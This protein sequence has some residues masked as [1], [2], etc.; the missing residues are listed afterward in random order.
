MIAG[1]WD[2]SPS[3]FDV[4]AAGRTAARAPAVRCE[5]GERGNEGE[6]A[7]LGPCIACISNDERPE[8]GGGKVSLMA[9]IQ[10]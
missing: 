5:K 3:S 2:D 9:P 10:Y 4:R 1:W 7:A 8:Q 6:G